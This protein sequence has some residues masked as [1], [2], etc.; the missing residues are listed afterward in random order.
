M[1]EY[2]MVGF[3]LE[4]MAVEDDLEDALLACS[5]SNRRISFMGGG[6]DDDDDEGEEVLFILLSS[7][8]F[9]A[10]LRVRTTNPLP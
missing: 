9:W 4:Y 6:G 8:P 5:H 10:F 2:N 1:V 3:T 7:L